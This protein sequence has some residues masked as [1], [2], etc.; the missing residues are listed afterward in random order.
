MSRLGGS[1]NRGADGPP[2]KAF[3]IKIPA[4]WRQVFPSLLLG[5]M[6]ARVWDWA[7]GQPFSLPETVPVMLG[8]AA[9]VSITYL[10]Q[11]TLCGASGVTA[12]TLWGFRR[13]VSWG[14]IQTA[15]LA[16]Y[17]IVQPS[18]KLT[19]GQGR[20]YWIARDTQNLA[21]LHA[22]AR[23]HGGPD[24]SLTRVLETPAYRL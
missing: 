8:T 11:P 14:D 1:A 12:M 21:G 24:H 15:A 13:H 6:I 16:R 5:A 18:F 3:P 19:D 7:Q 10:L 23:E 17:F 2:V 4:L 9:F 22:L 20:T